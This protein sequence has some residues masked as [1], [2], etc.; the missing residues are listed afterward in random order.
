NFTTEEY[1]EA[2]LQLANDAVDDQQ[3]TNILATLCVLNNNK[4]KLSW[5]TCKKQEAQRA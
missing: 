5:Q 1:Q 3:A 4:E 2:C